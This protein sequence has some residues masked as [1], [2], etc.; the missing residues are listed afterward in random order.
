MTN[1]ST[2]AR[3]PRKIV[4][5]VP[6]QEILPIVDGNFE[7]NV[8]GIYVIGDV[9]GLPLVKVAAN[10]GT[11][12]LQKMEKQGRFQN[13]NAEG[14]DLVIIGAGPAGLSAALE[15]KD[16]GLRYVVLERSKVAS[17]VR[18]FPPGK[19]VY[20]EPRFLKNISQIDS[21]GDK[22]KDDF[23]AMVEAL[24]AEKD[25]QVKEGVEVSKV[26]RRSDQR[27]DVRT[28]TGKTF[29][30]ANV[31]VAVGRQGQ[32]RLLE[33]PGADLAHKVTYR[34]HTAEDYHDKDVLIVGGGNSAIE[35]AL[36]LADH[37]RVT[38]SYRGDNF[39]RAKEDNRTLLEEAERAGRLCILYKSN[40]KAIHEGV[41]D[42]EVDG[43]IQ[44][45]TNDNVIVLIGT[46]PPV[47]FLLYMGLELD[48]VWTKKRV[49]YSGLG[50]AT[51]IFIYF[52]AKY[53]S[54]HP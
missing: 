38:L 20:A 8:P 3:R 36:M 30:T 28:D 37:N 47:D 9:T 48:G 6:P 53:F 34:L 51:G 5:T 35:A 4:A 19:K 16:R 24:V 2:Q 13:S 10:H 27:F 49:L 29:E 17:T 21:E 31:V 33:A 25:L 12:L 41:V 11:E 18:S 32:P 42:I 43:A 1:R 52:F 40:V 23:L 54:L 45:L 22:E 39:Y 46:L 50:I 44:T 7:S 15:A 26:Q 14:L